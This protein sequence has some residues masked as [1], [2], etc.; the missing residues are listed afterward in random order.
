MECHAWRLQDPRKGAPVPPQGERSR[1]WA[2]KPAAWCRG[3]GR[4]AI[5]SRTYLFGGLCQAAYAS[6]SCT[7]SSPAALRSFLFSLF[8]ALHSTG[9][10]PRTT[11][12]HHP[13]PAAS[14]ALLHLHLRTWHTAACA[15]LRVARPRS[16]PATSCGCSCSCA[17]IAGHMN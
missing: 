2:A 5:N 15:A 7:E 11:H 16:V 14:S 12:H 17:F 9:K 6:Q 3:A 8:A 1:G 10:A 4:E 13:P